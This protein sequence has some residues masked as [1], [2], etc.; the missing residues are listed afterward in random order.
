MGFPGFWQQSRLGP[1][2]I[3]ARD[4]VIEIGVAQ[5]SIPTRALISGGGSSV[6]SAAFLGAMVE[7]PGLGFSYLQSIW[8]LLLPLG[9]RRQRRSIFQAVGR[10]PAA[11]HLRFFILGHFWISR[12]LG[13]VAGILI[14]LLC[15]HQI[16]QW[17]LVEIPAVA[18]AISLAAHGNPVGRGSR[19]APLDHSTFWAASKKVSSQG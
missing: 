8:P 7:L 16:L 2:G 11:V 1:G 13:L 12:P 14:G 19:M 18:Q 17:F 4:W 6:H 5:I 9:D 10:A 15:I 3:R